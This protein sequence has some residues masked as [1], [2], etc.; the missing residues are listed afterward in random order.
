MTSN[1]G[2]PPNGGIPVNVDQ[3]RDLIESSTTDETVDAGRR[4]EDRLR[5]VAS[6]RSST[7]NA[8]PPVSYNPEL[9]RLEIEL[10]L[11]GIYRQYGFDFRSYAYASIRRR[12]WR[13][14]EAEGLKTV[15]ALQERVLHEPA[16]MEMLL[17]DLSINVT[18][19]F[20]DPAFYLA[21]RQRVIPL[22]RTYPFIRIWHAGCSTGE[23]VYSM[24]ILLEEEGLTIAPASTPPTST[25]SS[26]SGRVPA[27]SRSTGCR[28]TRRTTSGPAGR[29]RSP[30][31]TPRSTTV[32]CSRRR[33]SE[34]WC[35]RSTISSPTG[36]SPSS[37]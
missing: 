19:M 16:M 29:A 34:T 18:A 10:L 12:L 1:D 25:R 36:R 24:A 22:L 27:S 3:R 28:N 31:T 8:T 6:T 17:L 5:A 9:E 37:T 32:R 11:E 35:S 33:C 4:R 7:H 15:S 21:F 26:S 2:L 23:E 14:I 13:R 30:S 20:R